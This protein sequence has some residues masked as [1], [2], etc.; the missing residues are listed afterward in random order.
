VKTTHAEGDPVA[1]VST[2]ALSD[3]MEATLAPVVEEYDGDKSSLSAH[4]TR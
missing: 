3:A 4:P 2:E 1:E